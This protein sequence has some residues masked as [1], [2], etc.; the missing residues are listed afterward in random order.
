MTNIILTQETINA[1][2]YK[3]LQVL[4]KA[5]GLKASGKGV[6]TDSLRA[7]LIAL[8]PTESD[9]VQVDECNTGIPVGDLSITMDNAPAEEAPAT[10][11][12]TAK[13]QPQMVSARYVKL[14]VLIQENGS[15]RWEYK[16]SKLLRYAPMKNE[17]ILHILE[18]IIKGNTKYPNGIIFKF[19]KSQDENVRG[20]EFIEPYKLK[21]IFESV[22]G[23]D[24]SIYYTYFR[25][26]RFI[27][28][29]QLGSRGTK[30]MIG[31]AMH[32]AYE[33]LQKLYP[34]NTESN[35]PAK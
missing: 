22:M 5:N 31:K 30:Y 10:P 8:I 1:A 27:A 18:L 4:A 3:E 34:V 25:Q 24:N 12:D 23:R 14:P 13:I 35:T 21:A 16:E 11:V 15:S 7:Q 32:N 29:A 33:R 2:S 17:Q 26:M 19:E 28:K 9:N 20:K 6:T